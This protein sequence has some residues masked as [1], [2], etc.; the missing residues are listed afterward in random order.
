LR[1]AGALLRR[2]RAAR[3]L[4]GVIV[5]AHRERRLVTAFAVAHGLEVE[6]R[7]VARAGGG[8]LECGALAAAV[9]EAVAAGPGE[10]GPAAVIADRREELLVIGSVFARPVPGVAV[11]RWRGDPRLLA[12][13]IAGARARV[14]APAL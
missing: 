5:A 8:S 12:E 9:A 10:A 6:R 11:V 13:E 1:P 7:P 2:I 3:A 4:H 14:G